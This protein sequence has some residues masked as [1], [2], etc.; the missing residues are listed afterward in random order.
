[1]I[2]QACTFTPD[3]LSIDEYRQWISDEDHG[4]FKS[5]QINGV[6]INARFLP[7]ELQAYREYNANVSKYDSI[8]KLY[9]CGLT[10]QIEL[11]ADKNDKS[12]GSLLYYNV[13]NEQELSQRV[14]YLNFN[15]AEFISL[16]YN[17]HMYNPVLANFE[18]YDALANRMRFVIVFD[19]PEY[20][21][22]KFQSNSKD[23]LQLTYSDPVWNLG[24]NHFVF[25]KKDIL[26]IPKLNY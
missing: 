8:L 3:K 18:G 16:K 12:Y 22:G 17:E 10:F 21:C 1:M 4:L 24:V 23:E 6:S 25:E 2:F 15:T 11:Q 26:T 7:A 20:I 14:Q 5:R 19:I 13:M 9:I